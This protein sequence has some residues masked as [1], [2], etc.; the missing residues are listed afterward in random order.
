MLSIYTAFFT[1]EDKQPAHII[2][3]AWS[4]LQA[5]VLITVVRYLPLEYVALPD[6][7]ARLVEAFLAI[8]VVALGIWIGH[9]VF[10]THWAV[11]FTSI[12]AAWSF[13]QQFFEPHAYDTTPQGNH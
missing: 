4:G 10:Q 1:L 3:A 9:F 6:R 8:I 12:I 13:I 2:F 7:D 5:L 11:T